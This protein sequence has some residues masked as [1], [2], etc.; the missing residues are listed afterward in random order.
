[1]KVIVHQ[2]SRAEL[3]EYIRFLE[4]LDKHRI[5]YQRLLLAENKRHCAEVKHLRSIIRDIESG[6]DRVG[7]VI[8]AYEISRLAAEEEFPDEETV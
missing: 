5:E 1:M 6:L 8:N 4:F 7:D 2:C 3:L